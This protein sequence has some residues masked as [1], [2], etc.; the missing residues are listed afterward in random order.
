MKRIHVFK[1]QKEKKMFWNESTSSTQNMFQAYQFYF[2]LYSV[3]KIHS[4][5]LETLMYYLVVWTLIIK[6]SSSFQNLNHFGPR[7][8][9]FLKKQLLP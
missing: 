6:N 1:N 2:S 7:K 5:L 3:Y 9:I 8:K 4:I